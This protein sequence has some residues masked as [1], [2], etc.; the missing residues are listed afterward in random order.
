[1]LPDERGTNEMS[2]GILELDDSQNVIAFH[3][4]VA[5]P[6]GN[7]ANGAVYI[8]AP[9]VIEDIAAKG[10]AHVDLSTEIIPQLIP[11]I[12][13]VEYTGFFIDIGT[14]EAL[15][16]ARKEFPGPAPAVAAE[17]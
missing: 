2:S 4:K 15:E 11:R 8:F 6:P 10:R 16:F 1:M 3:E 9:D 5:N 13:A 14:P 17:A 7:L 12:R